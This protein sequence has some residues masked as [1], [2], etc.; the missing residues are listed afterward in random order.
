M[1]TRIK[2]AMIYGLA[3]LLVLGLTRIYP[4]ILSIALFALLLLTEKE[5]SFL[6]SKEGRDTFER[7]I[8]F[9]QGLSFL[10]LPLYILLNPLL[11]I[12]LL[13][14]YT[15]S[16]ALGS[17]ETWQ[18]ALIFLAWNFLLALFQ[19]GRDLFINKA[20]DLPQS[21]L[22]IFANFYLSLALFSMNFAFFTLP[23]AWELLC[24]FLISP[25]ISDSFAY[26]C[27][28]L[29]GKTKICPNIS[30]NKT[31]AG[32]LGSIIATSIF[33]ALLFIVFRQQ[34]SLSKLNVLLAIAIGMLASALCQV[35][36]L[37]ASALKRYKGVKD[38]GDLIPGHG[39]ILDRLDSTYFSFPFLTILALLIHKI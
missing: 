17:V 32:A 15:A 22:K 33:Y 11:E 21:T 4:F 16:P 5:L 27:G 36:D 38:S 9:L 20:E 2:S 24:I 13:S 10:I 1:K 3:F 7:T 6:L 12:D 26:F 30:P 14:K 37:F 39:G 18:L 8:T 25:W 31:L 35:G 23:Y 28:K 34:M 19:F 29:L